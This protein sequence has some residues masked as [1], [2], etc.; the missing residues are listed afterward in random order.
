M[1]LT[2][3]NEFKLS[4]N[5]GSSVRAK[6]QII[7]AHSTAT[8]N[9]TAAAIARNMKR[10][11]NTA[12][13]YTHYAVDDKGA[14]V[15]GEPGYVAW[16]A[17]SVANA[18]SPC[19]IELCEFTD[20]KKAIAAYK[21]YILLI[22][23]MANKFGIALTLDTKSRDGVKTHNWCTYNLGDTNHVDPISYLSSIGISQAQFAADIAHGVT[24]TQVKPSVP[25]ETQQKSGV[26]FKVPGG[27]VTERAKFTNGDTPI[28][29]RLGNPSLSAKSAGKLPAYGVFE[30]D[31]WKKSEGYTWIHHMFT[32]ESG[33]Y[34]VWC[35]IRQWYGN[36]S[37]LWGTIN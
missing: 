10:D 36:T 12:Q 6:Y 22:R 35:P 29:V 15:I 14:W 1:S 5:E 34:D 9:G 11:V 18:I 8:P 31:S 7:V 27:A 13:T 33:T 16:G 24:S 20:K 37:V 3:N 4:C 25:H 21:N 17:G 19:Q 30:Y 26:W 23:Q 2:I 32:D 28:T